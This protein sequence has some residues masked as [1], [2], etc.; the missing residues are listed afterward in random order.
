MSRSQIP[1]ELR[2]LKHRLLLMEFLLAALIVLF[3]GI[4]VLALVMS[5]IL[6]FMP[7]LGLGV[8]SAVGAILVWFMRGRL[9][10]AAR[11]RLAEAGWLLTTA[12]PR[13][14]QLYFN[15]ALVFDGVV[16]ALL[17]DETPIQHR[18]ALIQFSKLDYPKQ[19]KTPITLF[20]DETCPTL[21][22]R[23]NGRYFDGTWLDRDAFETQKRRFLRLM[24]SVLIGTS[25]FCGSVV[26]WALVLDQDLGLAISVIGVW[27][28]TFVLIRYLAMHLNRDRLKQI[29]SRIG[30][31]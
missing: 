18:A 30:W 8:L 16:C 23:L 2:R 20:E 28:A 10:G 19:D 15:Q 14:V 29:E 13:K 6:L 9:V 1:H 12:Q 24:N 26:I 25:L 22:I 3:A 7:L 11:R 21:L 27:L 31:S 5:A 4:L 17:D